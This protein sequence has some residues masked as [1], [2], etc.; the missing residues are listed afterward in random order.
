MLLRFIESG[1]AQREFTM[2]SAK[3]LLFDQTHLVLVSVKLV[4]QKTYVNVKWALSSNNKPKISVQEETNI[5][6]F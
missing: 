4:R 2:D 6:I 3:S 5:S 1:S